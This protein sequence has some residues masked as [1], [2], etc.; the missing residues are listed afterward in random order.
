MSNIEKQIIE[1]PNDT[2]S[3][4]YEDFPTLNKDVEHIFIPNGCVYGAVNMRFAIFPT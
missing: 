4:S 2:I 1:L 3:V